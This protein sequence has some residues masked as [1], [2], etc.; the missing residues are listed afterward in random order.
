M[1][2]NWLTIA[3]LVFLA[4]GA[5]GGFRRGLLLVV[6]SLAGYVGGLIAAARYQHAVTSSLMAVLPVRRLV[7]RFVPTAQGSAFSYHQGVNLFH[8]ILGLLVF[9]IMV[10]LAEAVAR[11]VGVAITR[12]VAR[13]GLLGAAN[14]VG[15]LAGGLAENAVI[16]GLIFGLLLSLPIFDGTPIHHVIVHNA[17]ALALAHFVNHFA[18]WRAERWV[19]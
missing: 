2:L 10:G 3:V 1:V 13:R 6:F 17:L 19:A 15:G 16:G 11:A 4:L 8:T 5:L 7:I 9:L 12:V 14:R 18:N